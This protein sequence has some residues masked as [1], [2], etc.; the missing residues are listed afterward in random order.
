MNNEDIIDGCVIS[1]EATNKKRT[2]AS[3]RWTGTDDA[4]MLRDARQAC[5]NNNA[6]EM[7]AIARARA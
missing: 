5:N 1:K 6:P 7:R 4:P 3:S 2:H